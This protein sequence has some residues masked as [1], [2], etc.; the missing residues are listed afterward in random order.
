M[1]DE[2]LLQYI[3]DEKAYAQEVYRL[4]NEYRVKMGRNPLVWE[5]TYCLKGAAIAAGVDCLNGMRTIKASDFADH[6]ASQ[7][8]YGATGYSNPKEAVEGWIASPIHRANILNSSAKT[9]GVA[10]FSVKFD[11]G[12]HKIFNGT[13]VVCTISSGSKE[14]IDSLQNIIKQ[15]HLSLL[16][17]IVHSEEEYDRYVGW[18]YHP[19][20]E[21][22]IQS[23]DISED[24]VFDSG[25]N[26]GEEAFSSGEQTDNVTA[27]ITETES[28]D[29]GES[30]E[31]FVL[32][33][34]ENADTENIELE[35]NEEE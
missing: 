33:E 34:S 19:V 8:G 16:R 17:T 25:S 13:S 6:G 14:R 20:G 26:D 10:Y 9:I 15:E 11:D 24:A 35:I 12:L 4:I 32:D 28:A 21:A 29:T 1:S 2:E 22:T 18:F 7:I 30:E 27:D 5:N 31:T 23:A 3:T